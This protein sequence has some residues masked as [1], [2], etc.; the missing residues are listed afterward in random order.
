MQLDATFHGTHSDTITKQSLDT[1]QQIYGY[2]IFNE[3]K[4]S[5]LT[6]WQ[7]ALSLD[8]TETPDCRSFEYY[9]IELDGPISMLKA[10]VSMVLLAEDD[11]LY[12]SLSIHW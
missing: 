3:N 10:W 2:M 4:F 1:F 7:H 9:L 8:H 12:A 6:N 11:W 5:I